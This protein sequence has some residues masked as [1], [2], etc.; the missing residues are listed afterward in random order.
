MRHAKAGTTRSGAVSNKPVSKMLSKLAAGKVTVSFLASN[1][2]GKRPTW[3]TCSLPL[4][5]LPTRWPD[6]ASPA[7]PRPL[8]SEDHQTCKG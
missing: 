2:P 4:C 3:L 7:S 5:I 1:Q 6:R 8:L